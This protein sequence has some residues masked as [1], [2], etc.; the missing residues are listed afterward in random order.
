LPT[1][2]LPI[3][4]AVGVTVTIVV[5]LFVVLATTWIPLKMRRDRRRGEQLAQQDA[6]RGDLAAE[7]EEMRRT[8]AD[9]SPDPGKN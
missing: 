7:V 2:V 8:E 6:E 3:G 4:S 5:V 9:E 1:V